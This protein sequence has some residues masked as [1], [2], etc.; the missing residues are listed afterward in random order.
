MTKPSSWHDDK[1]LS[2]HVHNTMQDTLNAMANSTLSM[3][4][5]FGFR[6]DQQH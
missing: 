1:A 4:K 2:E 5:Q 3:T 6:G